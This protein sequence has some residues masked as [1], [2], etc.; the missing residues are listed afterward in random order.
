[1]S[2]P[3]TNPSAK[4]TDSSSVTETELPTTAQERSVD[5]TFRFLNDNKHL[6]APPT[7]GDEAKLKRKLYLWVVLL[8]LVIELMLYVT[9]DI[10]HAYK[11]AYTETSRRLTSLP[12]PMHRS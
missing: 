3:H 7:A 2:G 1:M 9:T 12:Y 4:V 11:Y 8:A 5:L 6:V 10:I